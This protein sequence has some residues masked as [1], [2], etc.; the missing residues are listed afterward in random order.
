[1]KGNHPVMKDLE[2]IHEIRG[3]KFLFQIDNSHNHKDY[4]KYENLR[5]E[6]WAEPL[7][8]LP[9]L[10]NMVCENYFNDGSAL[11]IGVYVQDRKGDLTVD[12]EHLAGFSYGFVGVRDKSIGFRSLDNLQFYSQYTGV[13]NEYQAFGLGV[14]IKEFQKKALLDIFGISTVVCTYDPLTGIN[15]YRNIHRFGMDVI[16]Y[17]ESHYG[18]FGGNLNRSDI[19]CDRFFLSWDLKKE[20][21]RPKYAL[22]DLL[23]LEQHVI[24]S[25]LAEIKGKTGN[26]NLE[27]V[28]GVDLDL[29]SEYLL[30]EIPLD[31]YMMLRETDV[32]DREIRKIPLDWRMA[33]RKAFVTLLNRGYQI[34][35]FR[36]VK[37]KERKRDF[38]ILKKA[39]SSI[40]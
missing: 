34:I 20:I 29:E 5:D 27:V 3:T 6:I 38:Y 4:Q 11:F 12:E 36:L 19:P 1:M 25:D 13:K 9:G 18:E 32:D 24:Q 37:D 10:R 8:T 21:Q 14:L 16:S 39:G 22:K 26:V 2:T 28:Q 40:R 31:Y 33:T 17:N 7:D 30:V 35:D 15:A 23:Q